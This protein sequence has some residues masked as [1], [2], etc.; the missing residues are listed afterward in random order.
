[1]LNGFTENPSVAYFAT[2]RRAA[3]GFL[4]G[5][6]SSGTVLKVSNGVFEP[7][8][9]DRAQS[10]A[11]RNLQTGSRRS[12]IDLSRAK[13]HVVTAL[14]WALDGQTDALSLFQTRLD[15]PPE[16]GGALDLIPLHFQD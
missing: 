15:P 13:G 16:F 14:A 11:R 9:H 3:T 5:P 8:M 12:A 2:P 4:V 6:D 1:M 10:G 7:K